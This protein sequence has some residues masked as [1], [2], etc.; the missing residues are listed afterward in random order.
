MNAPFRLL[1]ALG[2]L[3][4]VLAGLYLWF[5]EPYWRL[6]NRLDALKTEEAVRQ[7]FGAPSRIVRAGEAIDYIPG[8]SHADR[9]ITGKLLVYPPGS[10]TV[11]PPDVVLYVYIDR[12]GRIEQSVVGR[13]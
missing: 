9:A 8:Y 1:V 13:R 12:E 5:N 2:V 6:E 11:D 4:W 10:G 7:T 3:A